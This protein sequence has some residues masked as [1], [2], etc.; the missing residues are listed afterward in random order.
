M[1][2]RGACTNA[3]LTTVPKAAA[4]ARWSLLERNVLRNQ[5]AFFGCLEYLSEMARLACIRDIQ[6]SSCLLDFTAVFYRGQ[7]G[8]R[9]CVRPIALLNN[10]WERCAISV[11]ESLNE[12]ADSAIAFFSDALREVQLSVSDLRR[13]TTKAHSWYCYLR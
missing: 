4:V 7:I 10:Q 11:P 9:V 2:D 5:T 13:I 1:S 12:N 8:G 3:N 6:Y